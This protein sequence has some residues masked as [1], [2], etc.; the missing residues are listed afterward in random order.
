[1]KVELGTPADRVEEMW[2]TLDAVDDPPADRLHAIVDDEQLKG[3]LVMTLLGGV[4]ALAMGYITVQQLTGPLDIVGVG[5]T[6]ACWLFTLKV[7]YEGVIRLRCAT[8]RD[9]E[10]PHCREASERWYAGPTLPD[11]DEDPA[12]T[13][14]PDP[15]RPEGL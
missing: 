3:D 9:Y 5:L 2:T 12:P 15:H 13:E 1:M 4:M 7:V 11:I 10:C 14:S 8:D 6:G